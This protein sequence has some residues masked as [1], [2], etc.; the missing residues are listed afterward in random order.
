MCSCE[1]FRALSICGSFRLTF[2]FCILELAPCACSASED[3]ES[4]FSASI[5]PS[6][7]ERPV[8]TSHSPGRSRHAKR[9]ER[10]LNCLPTTIQMYREDSQERQN[11]HSNL[12]EAGEE[13]DATTRDIG[14]RPVEVGEPSSGDATEARR[15]DRRGGRRRAGGG[16]P[17]RRRRI[18]PPRRRESG[19]TASGER[20]VPDFAARRAG[21]GP[22]RR[23]EANS[24]SGLGRRA[25]IRDRRSATPRPRARRRSRKRVASKT[26]LSKPPSTQQTT[27]TITKRRMELMTL[28]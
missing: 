27:I 8:S 24:R 15:V 20:G 4:P 21:G 13:P 11:M 7:D 3:E 25:G 28:Q 10:D 16:R 18:A 26:H 14:R 2:H 5:P 6:G 22:S 23:A 19:R 12:E 9:L 17:G 1:I